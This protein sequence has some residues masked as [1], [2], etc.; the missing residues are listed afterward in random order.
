MFYVVA[1]DIKDSKR[2]KK[3]ASILE[4]YGFRVNYSV[5]ELKI[6][7]K[8]LKE[9]LKRIVLEVDKK[10]DSIRF[11]NL[12]LKEINNSFEICNNVEIFSF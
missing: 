8:K 2:R 12:T 3:I 4:E 9:L 10:D 11:Y 5:F 1:Y 7:K 6:D